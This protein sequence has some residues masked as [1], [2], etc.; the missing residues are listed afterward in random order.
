[1]SILSDFLWYTDTLKLETEGTV[2]F[3]S[4][5]KN[6]LL[7]ADRTA[8]TEERAEMLFSALTTIFPHL[9]ISDIKENILLKKDRTA[10]QETVPVKT[11][12]TL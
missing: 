2:Q 11:L 6:M 4:I 10:A 1:M 3:R 9:L 7:Q 8:V 5:V 12:P